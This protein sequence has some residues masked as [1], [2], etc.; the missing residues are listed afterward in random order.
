[1]YSFISLHYECIT[2]CPTTFHC[3]FMFL[4]VASLQNRSST[5]KKTFLR[6]KIETLGVTEPVWLQNVL[7]TVH[8]EIRLIAASLNRSPQREKNRRQPSYLNI[9]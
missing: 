2:S 3:W 1:M 8:S 7:N 5:V 6:V 9:S 4:T